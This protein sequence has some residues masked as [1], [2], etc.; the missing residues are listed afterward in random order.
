MLY[1]NKFNE[2]ETSHQ[3]EASIFGSINYWARY[4][5]NNLSIVSQYMTG[6]YNSCIQC[7]TCHY[8]SNTFEIFTTLTLDIPENSPE[9]TIY[10]CLKNFT[11]VEL[12]KEDNQY[13]CTHCNQKTDGKKIITFWNVPNVLIIHLKRFQNNGTKVSKNNKN[14]IFDH[15][16]NIGEFINQFNKK[17]LNYQLFGVIQHFGQMNGGHYISFNK[18]SDGWYCFDDSNVIKVNEIDKEIMTNSSYVL[19][20][21]TTDT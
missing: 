21:S 12:L 4:I 18:T 8:N 15:H 7:Q 17:N 1:I 19:I 9:P 11:Q 3:R 14:V 16:L 13:H 2:Y 6:I 5:E 20:Y 10:D